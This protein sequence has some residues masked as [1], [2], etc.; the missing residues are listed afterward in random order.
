MICKNVYSDKESKTVKK[1][2]SKKKIKN[3]DKMVIETKKKII[4][5]THLP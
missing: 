1:F 5:N 2:V 4:L 3:C